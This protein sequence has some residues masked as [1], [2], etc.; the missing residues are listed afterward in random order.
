MYEPS[1]INAHSRL[2]LN[3]RIISL[4]MVHG[5]TLDFPW[6]EKDE[7]KTFVFSFKFANSILYQFQ[8]SF[9]DI[10]AATK[11]DNIKTKLKF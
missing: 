9:R 10:A 1:E 8:L 2:L 3:L 7:I 6:G 5:Y 4:V 11:A